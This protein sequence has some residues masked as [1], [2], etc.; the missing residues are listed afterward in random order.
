MSSTLLSSASTT[1]GTDVGGIT[2]LDIAESLTG[3]V[4]TP[5]AS[6][7]LVVTRTGSWLS[8]DGE[9]GSESITF[10]AGT[11]RAFVTNAASDQVDILDLANPS[12]PVKVGEIDLTTLPG[13]G[14]VNS[15]AVHD[16]VVA[17]AVQNADGGEPGLVA[18]YDTD[19]AL[20]KTLTVGVLPDQVTFSPDGKLLLVAN[21]GEPFNDE[22]AGVIE[23]APGTVSI[24][25]LSGGAAAASVRNT[26]GFSALDGF[27]AAL[28]DLGIKIF[29]GSDDL[30]A[31]TAAQDIEPEYITVS[32]DGTTAYVTLQEVNA[33]AAIDLTDT[34]AD[35]PVSILP[36]GYVDFSLAGNEGDFSDRDGEGGSASISVGNAPVK[37][38]LQPDAIASFEVAGTTYFVT[39]N[40]GDTR[41]VN[42][43]SDGLNEKRA[44]GFGATDADYARYNL[45]TT[46]SSDGD[47]V[48]FGGRGFSIFK[49]NADGTIVKVEETGGDFE[50]ILAELPN[51]ATVFNGQNGGAFDTRS[52]NKAAEPE[53]V[54]VGEVDGKSYAFIGLERI[55]GVMVW[56]VTDPENASYVTYMPATSEDYGPEVLKFVAADESPS[57][58]ALLLSAN[59]ISGSVT[60]YDLAPAEPAEEEVYTLQLLHFSDQEAG[61]LAAETAPN[62]A[63]LVDAFDDDYANTLI[64]SSGDN[65]IPGP[66]L[67]AGTDPSVIAALNEVTGSTLSPTATV[68]LGAVDMSILNAIGVEASAIGNHEF[69]LGSRVLRDAI[70]SGSASGWV[71]AA[72]PYVN[73]NLSFGPTSPYY[74]DGF[75]TDGD[76]NPRY[77]DTLDYNSN[78]ALNAGATT[79]EVPEASSL[80]GRI[81][82]SA[83]VTEGGE[84]IG[85][86][87]V[88]TQMLEAISSPTNVE[89]GGF[90]AGTGANGEVDDMDLLA[91]Q[92]QPVI[93][94][95]IAEG[96]NKIVLL[97]HL[98][99]LSLEKELATKLTGV[100]IIVAGGSHTRLADADDELATFPGHSADAADTYP[101]VTAGVDGKTTLIVN[102]DNE[103]T[104]LGRL[105]VDFDANGDIILDS[106]TENLALNGAWASTDENVAEAWGVDVA[107]LDTTAFADGTK[108][109]DVETLTEAVSDVINDKDGNILGLTSVYLEGE[110]TY[111][112]TQE[113]NLGDL[114]ADAN[115]WYAQQVD[116]EVLVSVKNG[117]GIRAAIGTVSSPDP[118][119]GE[120]DKLP[121]A[122]NA[123]AG[124][125][126]GGISQLDIENSLRFNNALSLIT[127]T[128]EQ[129][130]KVLEHAV[131]ATT[132]TS[133]PG[134]F[135]QFGGVA[136]SYDIDLPV[137]ER[138]LSAALTGEDGEVILPLVE[139]GELV[140]DA[141]MAIR[142][143]TLSYLVTGGDSYPFAAF[144]AE[145]PDFANV[146][147][148]TADIVPDAG[149]SADFAAEGTEQDAFAEY[150]QEFFTQTPFSTAD[151]GRDGDTRIQNL[152]YRA[153]TV[154]DGVLI[155]GLAHESL[156]GTADDDII[157]GLDGRDDLNGLGGDDT[158]YGGAGR[159][160]LIGLDGDD[161]LIGGDASDILSGGAGNDYLD[162]GA[163]A[164][165]LNG[166]IGDDTYVVDQAG[167]R[168]AEVARNGGIDTVLTSLDAYTLGAHVENLAFTGTGA[169][170]GT[171]NALDNILTGGAGRDRLYGLDGNDTLIG[172]VGRDVLIAGAGNDRLDGG[173]GTDD[174]YAGAGADTLVFRSG[175]GQDTV[176]DFRIA[177]GDVIELDAGEFADFAALGSA[178]ADTAAGAT[179][180]YD[181]GSTLLLAHVAASSLGAD[182]FRFV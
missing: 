174:L 127:V 26:I 45:D 136:F 19:G 140:V 12:A 155:A 134:Q 41:I 144:A 62:L 88:T 87:G 96:V 34:G 113:T 116:G 171:G 66:F 33:V 154:L 58:H 24:I 69:D 112:R 37:G 4:E 72:F 145:N 2:I 84:K 15:V 86:L 77:T 135:G 43:G 31:P 90:P 1:T 104:Y 67:A 65:F 7:T 182:D 146:V 121:P 115:L 11:K 63:A 94:E 167:D 48:G 170:S 93:D 139:N 6:G 109:D 82:P 137:G 152:D 35:K 50:Q 53:G 124:K 8:G 85:L 177:D 123:D 150:L 57:G 95:L 9:G 70:T 49:Q 18:L 91:A 131:A 99:Q 10:D 39:A 102:T 180:T 158:L 108:G 52:D 133:T 25:D 143:V 159:D 16:G 54:V 103:Y 92:I 118:V 27:E 78:A 132:A 125:P 130:V 176:F 98:Q 147:N 22:V 107:D 151:T 38:L 142:V 165:R 153:D 17:V 42:N 138:V 36:L 161:T 173:L 119:T 60:V 23:N 44:S 105:V 168:I 114:S 83:V 175:Y 28:S 101:L 73:T 14:E 40:E 106:L 56:D 32:P 148:L 75:P 13:Y 141:D 29:A 76:L 126:D 157:F 166:G 21:E 46:W 71:G 162:G 68:P 3:S 59:E 120:I 172:G 122:A 80:A 81:V 117:G 97:S 149:Q 164:D 156:D 61:L 79:T 5:V 89:V 20:I 179:I 100:D 129:M 47:Y 30:P 128:A 160:R 55:G 178:L 51:A 163:G 110:R 181:D 169:F 74:Q 64:L 111:V